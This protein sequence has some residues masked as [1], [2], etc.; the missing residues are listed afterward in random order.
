MKKLL[1]GICIVLMAAA[2]VAVMGCGGE[3]NKPVE[4]E[5]IETTAAEASA[6]MPTPETTH[7][8]PSIEYKL[9]TIHAGYEVEQDD[10]LVSQFK[11][12]VDS[13]MSKCPGYTSTNVGDI[14]VTA[15]QTLDDWG[16]PMSLLEVSQGIDASIVPESVISLEEVSAA[17][18]T[19]VHGQ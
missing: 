5:E 11:S 1:A 13:I 7:S 17:F 16:D 12:I 9:A 19:I 3:E 6:E 4:V 18:V 2:V 15:K 14:L 10:P 8:E